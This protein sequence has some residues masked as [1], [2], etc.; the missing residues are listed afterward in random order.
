MAHKIE[1]KE[2]KREGQSVTLSLAL[3]DDVTS[4]TVESTQVSLTVPDVLLASESLKYIQKWYDD[5][6]LRLKEKENSNEKKAELEIFINSN[7]TL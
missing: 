2:F 4:A 6:K 1:I 3:V 7:L 5:L